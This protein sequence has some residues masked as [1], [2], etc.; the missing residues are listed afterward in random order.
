MLEPSI[1]IIVCIKIMHIYMIF[2]CSWLKKTEGHVRIKAKCKSW[3]LIRSN[4][5][6]TW[7][8]HVIN[9]FETHTLVKLQEKR[10]IKQ[11]RSMK[12]R[13]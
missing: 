4:V 10:D 12:L 5:E 8:N 2:K 11:L 7:E 3:Y 1:F 9:H 6:R 13:I